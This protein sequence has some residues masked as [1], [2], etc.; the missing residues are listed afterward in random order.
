MNKHQKKIWKFKNLLKD[1]YDT[2]F[3]KY[4]KANYV[5][6]VMKI[7]KDENGNVII[8][9]NGHI[10]S[11]GSLVQTLPKIE[12]MA[13]IFSLMRQFI[14]KKDDTSIYKIG[15]HIKA[16]GSEKDYNNYRESLDEFEK[17]ANGLSGANYSLEDES[18][19]VIRNK[20]YTRL[21][22]V[23]ELFYGNMVHRDD[24]KFNI[25]KD[26]LAAN[27][28]VEYLIGFLVYI[29]RIANVIKFPDEDYSVYANNCPEKLISGKLKN[30]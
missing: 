10:T 15:K 24:D 29:C 1:I 7:N 3:F 26:L 9:K 13:Y 23:E 22:L 27:K 2:T 19:K 28:I 6:K 14:L 25:G 5:P 17:Y 8:N 20:S 21:E 16:I 12:H 4:L 18:G 30:K 11:S